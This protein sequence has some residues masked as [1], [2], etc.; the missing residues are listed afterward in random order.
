MPGKTLFRLG[1]SF[2]FLAAIVYFATRFLTRSSPP[3]MFPE[4]R[5]R[6]VIPIRKHAPLHPIHY[7]HHW[8]LL[9]AAVLWILVFIFMIFQPE[10][11]R[12]IFVSLEKPE[13]FVWHGNAYQATISVYVRPP[14][15]FFINGQEIPKNS[16]CV[17]LLEQRQIPWTIYFE[18][19]SEINFREAVYAID[20]IQGCGAKLIWI[21]PKLRE[22][23][24][25][26]DLNA[27]R[28]R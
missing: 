2:L 17:K 15:H 13:F 8:G 23:W 4:M 27:R 1:L 9:W 14:S 10:P 3:R 19:D 21:T 6:N 25:H 24:K 22:E 5:L 26:L 11:R 12:G 16:L 20:V 28:K 7:P 18:A